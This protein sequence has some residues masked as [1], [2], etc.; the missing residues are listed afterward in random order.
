MRNVIVIHGQNPDAFENGPHVARVVAD[1]LSAEVR[2]APLDEFRNAWR[3]EIG[4]LA[5][6]ISIKFTEPAI[7]PGG[8]PIDLRL[9]GYD[10]ERLKAASGELQ[11]WFNSQLRSAVVWSQKKPG[12]V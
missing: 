6:V 3:E 11:A 10:L 1:L 5:D 2:D 7:G 8:R 4:E 9:L 12:I